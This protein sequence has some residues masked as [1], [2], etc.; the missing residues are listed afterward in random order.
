MTSIVCDA[1]APAVGGYSAKFIGRVKNSEF[2]GQSGTEGG[3]GG[4]DY[5]GKI[6]PDGDV[7]FRANGSTGDPN[8]TLGHQPQATPFT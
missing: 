7:E 2:R 1:I 8:V 3:A 5:Y 6:E 4:T